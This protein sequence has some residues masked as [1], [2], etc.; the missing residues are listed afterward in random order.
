MVESANPNANIMHE[1]DGSA[2]AP[3]PPLQTAQMGKAYLQKLGY[4]FRENTGSR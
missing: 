2:N 4:T 1:L 3:Y